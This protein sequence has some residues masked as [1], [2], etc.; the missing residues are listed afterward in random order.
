MGE[1]PIIT[2]VLILILLSGGITISIGIG[3]LSSHPKLMPY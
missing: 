2:T 3:I 1:H